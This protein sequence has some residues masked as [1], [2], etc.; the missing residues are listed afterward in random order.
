M[1]DKEPFGLLAQMRGG[2]CPP[3]QSQTL[4]HL[5]EAGPAKPRVVSSGQEWGVPEAGA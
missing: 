3:Q 4:P 2:L 5:P 1:L